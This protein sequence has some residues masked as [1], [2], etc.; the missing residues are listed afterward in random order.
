LLDEQVML[1]LKFGWDGSKK[2]TGALEVEGDEED[3]DDEPI[4][5]CGNGSMHD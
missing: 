2:T 5:R 3:L 4:P 1:I